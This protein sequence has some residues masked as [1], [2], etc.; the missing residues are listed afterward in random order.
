[1]TPD[2]DACVTP[3]RKSVHSGANAGCVEVA[4]LTGKR[5]G[6]RDSKDRAGSPVLS[7]RPREWQSFLGTV[8]TG[9]LDMT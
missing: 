5:V 2:S 8:K 7:F 9:D 6:V 1:M 4:R 3:W